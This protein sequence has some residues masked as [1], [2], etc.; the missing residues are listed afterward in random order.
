[1]P[2]LIKF[3][4]LTCARKGD[5]VAA[6]KFLGK[7]LT[8]FVLGALLG[9]YLFGTWDHFQKVGGFLVIAYFLFENRGSRTKR[10]E[11]QDRSHER[12]AAYMR[13]CQEDEEWVAFVENERSAK[14]GLY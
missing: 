12:D 5:K 7:Y 11:G 8:I 3:A 14:T 13:A 6:M 9:R 10:G 1:M 2:G 4:S